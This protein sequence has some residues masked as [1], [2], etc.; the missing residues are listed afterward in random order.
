MSQSTIIEKLKEDLRRV[1]EMLARL[2]AERE[3]INKGYTA[4]LEEENKIVE[5]MRK[6]R[7]E[8]KYMKLETRLNIVSRQRKEVEGKKTEIE[9]KIR[10]C[11]EERSKILMRIEY[12]KPKQQE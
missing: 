9:R 3:E 8:Y 6:C 4:I 2:E 7:D 5:E 1:D 11:A 12:L 10:G